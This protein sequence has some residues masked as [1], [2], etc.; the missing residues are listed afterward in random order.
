[1]ARSRTARPWSEVARAKPRLHGDDGEASAQ[2]LAWR[3]WHKRL[4]V[5]APH[6][7]LRS[8]PTHAGPRA[9]LP[10][11]LPSLWGLSLQM[12]KLRPEGA[13]SSPG[14]AADR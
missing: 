12:K 13:R 2:P 9:S 1:M 14:A 7:E 11:P 4:G 5:D 6:L 8:L 10:S 3:A